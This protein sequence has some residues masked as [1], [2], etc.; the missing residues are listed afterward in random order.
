MPQR[1]FDRP[2]SALHRQQGRDPREPG[3]L[4]I[5]ICTLPYIE[6]GVFN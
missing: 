2:H 3:K 1:A 5:F 4:P 6:N